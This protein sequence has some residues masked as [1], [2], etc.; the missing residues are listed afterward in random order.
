MDNNQLKRVKDIFNTFSNKKYNFKDFSEVHYQHYTFLR[1]FPVC[2]KKELEKLISY[3]IQDNYNYIIFENL[4]Q[5][6]DYQNILSVLENIII[7]KNKILNIIDYNPEKK[8]K[9]FLGI[10]WFLFGYY[11]TNFILLIYNP[12]NNIKLDINKISN[13]QY[14]VFL[15]SCFIFYDELLDS[16]NENISKETKNICLGFTKYFFVYLTKFENENLTNS[17]LTINSIYKEYLKFENINNSN[18]NNTEND[19]IIS[20]TKKLLEIFLKEYLTNPNKDILN[21]ILDLFITEL[22]AN[23]IQKGINKNNNN[24]D[25]LDYTILKSQKSLY[26]NLL[27]LIQSFDKNTQI[28]IKKN[29][30]VKY[31]TYLFGLYSQLM[32]DFNDIDIDIIENNNTIFIDLENRELNIKK[33]LNLIYFIYQELNTNNKIKKENLTNLNLNLFIFNYIISKNINNYKSDL[34]KYVPLYLSDLKDIRSK[35]NNFI[36]KV[37][38]R[39]IDFIKLNKF[40]PKIQVLSQYLKCISL[41]V[42]KKIFLLGIKNEIYLKNNFPNIIF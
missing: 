9:I 30:Y 7:H 37:D 31:L 8:K 14:Y 12:R 39:D 41:E 32:D 38:I 16:K 6:F 40:K 13:N 33:L 23:K 26:C 19:E 25:L 10:L 22:K 27:I 36:N 4:T 34:S 5:F 17:N 21:S 28:D 42:S 3:I 1:N 18:N 11:L 20:Q 15:T 2:N 24:I 35:K 29:E